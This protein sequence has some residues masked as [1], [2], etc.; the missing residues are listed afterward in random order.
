MANNIIVKDAN[1]SNVTMK[2]TETGGVHTASS[3]PEGEILEVL[4]AI[5]MTLNSLTK[6]ISNYQTASGVLQITGTGLG[7]STLPTV[8]TVSTVTTVSS[9]SGITNLSQLDTVLA[10]KITG[11]FTDNIRKNITVT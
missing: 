11:I 5:R 4:Q 7:I 3:I 1:S 6:I 2:T 8:S 10:P 9:V